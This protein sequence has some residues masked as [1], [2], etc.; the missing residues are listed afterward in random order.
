[1]CSDVGRTCRIPGHLRIE[2]YGRE[3]MV[4][5]LGMSSVIRDAQIVDTCPTLPHGRG[6][7]LAPYEYEYAKMK[8]VR[9]E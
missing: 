3:S 4:V 6:F 7:H 1:M 8:T 5:Q 9:H 2:S